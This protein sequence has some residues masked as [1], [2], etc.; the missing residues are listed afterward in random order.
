MESEDEDGKVGIL[1]YFLDLSE[2]ILS[3]KG[4]LLLTYPQKGTEERALTLSRQVSL[5]EC[6]TPKISC[7]VPREDPL[8]PGMTDDARTISGGDKMFTLAVCRGEFQANNQDLDK[9]NTSISLQD[10]MDEDLRQ[11][12]DIVR[13]EDT[14]A[15]TG[16]AKGFTQSGS[17]KMKKKKDSVV[18]TRQSSRIVRDGVL[19]VVKAQKRTSAKNDIT[20]MNRFS[21]LTNVDD[22]KLAS[23]A[24]DS[25]V[26][27]GSSEVEVVENI[28]TIKAKER[29][30]SLISMAKERPSREGEIDRLPE[31]IEID[32][33]VS[34]HIK[35]R[36]IELS[37]DGGDTTH[38]KCQWILFFGT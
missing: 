15:K 21:V 11:L 22:T 19:V 1:D 28:K 3:D 31:H 38:N 23:I 18:A 6:G 26:N 5:I 33:C 20:G 2:D 7:S 13:E 36:G 24:I 29:A 16:D 34:P 10:L 4:M 9:S 8:N 32:G 30:Q 35:A 27:L 17:K 12:E 37:A 25:G 14:Q